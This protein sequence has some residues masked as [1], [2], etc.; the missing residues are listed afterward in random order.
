MNYLLAN[1]CQM[2]IIKIN[3]QIL[4]KKN[5]EQEKIISKINIKV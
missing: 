1:K 3:V 5:K 4:K 2:N